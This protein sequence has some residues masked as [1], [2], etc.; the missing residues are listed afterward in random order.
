MNTDLKFPAITLR[1]GTTHR[2][3]NGK[4]LLLQCLA[5]TVWLTQAGDP[6]DIVLEP[7]GEAVIERNGLSLMTALSDTQ[8]VLL[9]ATP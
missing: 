3:D 8:F 4:G 6:R 7:G 5:G 9:S 1:Q 2:V